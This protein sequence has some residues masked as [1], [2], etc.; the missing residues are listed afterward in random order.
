M[1]SLMCFPCLVL[2]GQQPRNDDMSRAILRPGRAKA[3]RA[4][5]EPRRLSHRQTLQDDVDEAPV[6]LDFSVSHGACC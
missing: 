1:P 4:E 5:K 2:F 3:R 6:V